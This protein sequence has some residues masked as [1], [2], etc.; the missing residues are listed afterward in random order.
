MKDAETVTFAGATIDRAAGLRDDASALARLRAEPEA[1]CL[2]LWRGRPLLDMTAGPALGWLPPDSP[3][4]GPH[5]ATTV[6]LGLEAGAPRFAQAIPDWPGAPEPVPRGF[7]DDAQDGH[8]LLPDHYR[9]ND[10]RAA[11]ATIGAADAGHA[12]TAKGILGWHET[13][14]FCAACGGASAPDQG[15]WR[16]RCPACGAQHFPRTDP[17]VIMLV[18]RGNQVLLG[19]QAF[20]PPGMYSLLAGFMEP[21][22]TIEAAVRRETFEEAGILVGRVDYLASQPWP[23][24]SSLMIGCRGEALGATIRRDD[25]ELEDARWVSRERLVAALAGRDPEILPARP[26]AIAR[27]LIERWLADR[28]D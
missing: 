1:R 7:N 16:R 10:L 3:V 27:F 14:G 20:W 21:G 22:E 26:G 15:G 8:P 6:F 12:A 2:P 4:F 11:M 18:T 28:L 25:V 19:R 9:F 13:H 5:T 23:F 24:P 17:V